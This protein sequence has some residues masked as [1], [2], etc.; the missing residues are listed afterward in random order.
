MGEARPGSIL[1][2]TGG[3]RGGGSHNPKRDWAHY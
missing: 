3:G 1:N 2:E